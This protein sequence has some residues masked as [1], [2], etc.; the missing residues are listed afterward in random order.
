MDMDAP[1]RGVAAAGES[2]SHVRMRG[3]GVAAP[4]ARSP[5]PL[6]P[7]R[8]A[9]RHL[10]DGGQGGLRVRKSLAIGSARSVQGRCVLLLPHC[11]RTVTLCR[12]GH[13]AAVHAVRREER[14]RTLGHLSV[15]ALRRFHAEQL[16][17]KTAGARREAS[18]TGAAWVPLLPVDVLAHSVLGFLDFEQRMGARAVSRGMQRVA[19][20]GAC[21]ALPFLP[22]LRRRLRPRHPPGTLCLAGRSTCPT[23]C[24][25]CGSFSARSARRSTGAA[26][27]FGV[28]RVL[29]IVRPYR[30]APHCR[31]S[32]CRLSSCRP[33]SIPTS[34]SICIRHPRAD[35]RRPGSV[36][37]RPQAGGGASGA[38]P[39]RRQ[40][41]TAALLEDVTAAFKRAG[42]WWQYEKRRAL[43]VYTHVGA[44]AWRRGRNGVGWVTRLRK[45]CYWRRQLGKKKHCRDG[46]RVHKAMVELGWPCE[47][48]CG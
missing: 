39:S 33:H 40:K 44:F 32:A 1:A 6:Q 34:R 17:A 31:G 22:R 18:S 8:W 10:V 7:G 47:G 4:P 46:R 25:R 36:R 30:R 9:M 12:F 5:G 21:T 29:S 35:G 37:S 19:E 2:P 43:Q 28:R 13:V 27:V 20:R 48:H 45:V 16:A 24:E 11:H 14:Q 23:A 38:R 26:C 42:A 15:H 3:R 41:A